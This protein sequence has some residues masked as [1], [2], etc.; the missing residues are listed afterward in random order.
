MKIVLVGAGNVASCIAGTLKSAGHEIV[1][2][3]SRTAESASVLAESIGASFTTDLSELPDAEVFLTMLRDDALL[4]LAPQIVRSNQNTLFLHTSGSVPMSVWK[5]A[6]AAH[7]GVMYP[8]QTFSRG[9][10]VEWGDLPIFVEGGS[11]EDLETVTVLAESIS[12]NVSVLDSQ[13]RAKMHLAAVFACNFTNRMYAIS[14]A[15]LKECGIPFSVMKPLVDETAAKSSE[16]SP[17]LAQTGPAA[18][19]DVR[20]MDMHRTLLAT[21]PEWQELYDRISE[22]IKSSGK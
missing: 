10:Q 19:G 9:K 14:E 4:S 8:M 20:V 7:Y 11:Q 22:D 15:L 5:D 3:F 17:S 21:H 16:V 6:G 13:Q 2:V 1:C 18:R 12:G